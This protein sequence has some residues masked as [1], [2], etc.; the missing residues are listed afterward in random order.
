MS[1]LFT[2]LL[3][4]IILLCKGNIANNIWKGHS[5]ERS[6]DV[7]RH[8]QDCGG[9]YYTSSGIIDYPS[10]DVFFY[11]N[12]V[13]CEWIITVPEGSRIKTWFTFFMTETEYDKVIISEGGSHRRT[14]SGHL[15]FPTFVSETNQLSIIF[16][17]DWLVSD[18]GFILNWESI[19]PE[20]T[21]FATFN[22]MDVPYDEKLG[23]TNSTEFAEMKQRVENLIYPCLMKELGSKLSNYEVIGFRKDSL[24]VD[25][26][27]VDTRIT[28]TERE[29]SSLHL[30][31]DAI[32][33]SEISSLDPSSV[34]VCPSA[35]CST[36]EPAPIGGKTPSEDNLPGIDK[37]GVELQDVST[38]DYSEVN[39]LYPEMSLM[40]MMDYNK[41]STSLI[42]HRCVKVKCDP[43]VMNQPNPAR[44]ITSDP[45]LCQHIEVSKCEEP[46]VKTQCPT[47]CNGSP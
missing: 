37:G 47:L 26:L 34:A 19:L 44:K 14:Y 10:G 15:L 46:Q 6:K 42:C 4:C 23:D 27:I 17:S 25:T 8:Q 36:I 21:V 33:H 16:E 29:L 20:M 12:D 5:K 41:T 1:S 11:T 45:F 13:F 31:N 7:L 3:S 28:T 43:Q 18:Q 35:P 24:I 22:L 38:I 40:M 2:V 39:L 9:M 32:R 30:V